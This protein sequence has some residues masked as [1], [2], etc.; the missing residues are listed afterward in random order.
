MLIILSNNWEKHFRDNPEN[1]LSNRTMDVPMDLFDQYTSLENYLSNGIEDQNTVFMVKA[2]F[3]GHTT[4]IHHISKIGGR[5]TFLEEKVFTLV[6]TNDSSFPAQT[7]KE[8]FFESFDVKTP[9]WTAI[10]SADESMDIDKL[11]ARPKKILRP[12]MPLPL[13]WPQLSSTWG[14]SQP[15]T[16][17]T[18]L[19]VV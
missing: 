3:S 8:A 16:S 9:S 7:T 15:K 4:F 10:S 13:S 14:G 1:G 11:P 17:S 6:G 2:P 5:R 19:S 12:C 18:R